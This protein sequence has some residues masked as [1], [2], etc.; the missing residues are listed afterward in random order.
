MVFW[1]ILGF[2]LTTFWVFH[3]IFWQNLLIFCGAN[4]DYKWRSIQF[5]SISNF[6]RFSVSIEYSSFDHMEKKAEL[7]TTKL[8][9]LIPDFLRNGGNIDIAIASLPRGCVFLSLCPCCGAAAAAT[10]TGK[11][12]R[13]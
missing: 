11:V 9:I 12:R 5:F 4:S 8:I 3:Q 13:F 1:Q 2:S 10:Q 7:I 6:R